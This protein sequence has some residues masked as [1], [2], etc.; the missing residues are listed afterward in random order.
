VSRGVHNPGKGRS[1]D[2]WGSDDRSSWD[3]GGRVG[4][5]V[6][7]WSNGGDVMNGWSRGVG[8][9][10]NWGGNSVLLNGGI[11]PASGRSGNDMGGRVAD[12]GMDWSGVSDCGV[13]ESWNA[14]GVGGN[15]WR[16]DT[17]FSSGSCL[18][19]SSC[20][21]N[22]G[23]VNFDGVSRAGEETDG[24]TG[25]ALEATRYPLWSAT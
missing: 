16:D 19:V 14:S 4:H 21:L 25:R 12:G 9:M 18:G 15:K 20:V 5:G 1:S 17:S 7:S 10:L 24:A 8:H 6:V 2:G 13:T 23:V 11:T 3:M 22:L